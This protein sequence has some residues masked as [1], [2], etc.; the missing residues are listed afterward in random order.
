MDESFKILTSKDLQLMA[1]FE[2]FYTCRNQI[3]LIDI[4]LLMKIILAFC[5]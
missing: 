1:S 5:K 3:N 2:I 4:Y